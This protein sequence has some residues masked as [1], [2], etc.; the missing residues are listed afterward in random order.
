MSNAKSKV[1]ERGWLRKV[2]RV[3]T[4]GCIVSPLLLFSL[5]IFS[6]WY[7]NTYPEFGEH[8]ERVSWLPAEA[9]D[10]SFFK[11]NSYTAYE[12]KISEDGFRK[13]VHSRWQFEEISDK[14]VIRRYN[15]LLA[16]ESTND[17]E[18][19]VQT[20]ARVKNGIVT[21]YTKGSGGGYHA[22]YDRDT[23][24]GYIQHNPR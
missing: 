7:S 16:M 18:L 8:V 2:R 20:V 9:T 24:I 14:A 10:V 5:G 11:S 17:E 6:I 23:G 1:L 21:S 19:Q 3:A 22:I 12:F 4:I 13:C 15:Y